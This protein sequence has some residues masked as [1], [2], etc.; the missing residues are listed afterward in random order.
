MPLKWKI[1]YWCSLYNIIFIIAFV[2]IRLYALFF[3]DNPVVDNSDDVVNIILALTV[4]SKSFLSI[5]FVG[6]YN[7]KEKY[8]HTEYVL[9]IV[10]FS[11]SILFLMAVISLII[12]FLSLIVNKIAFE[13]IETWR[14]L[15]SLS[16]FIFCCT[17]LY[18]IIFDFPLLKAIRKRRA[19][20]VN[21]IG[22]ELV[23]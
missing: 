9:F 2:C 13:R 19:L 11:F 15:I 4:A 23:Q 14:L 8:G 17:M 6:Y 1:Y 21:D 18:N 20:G 10:G 12:Y 22:K 3:G 7:N 5:K 16:V